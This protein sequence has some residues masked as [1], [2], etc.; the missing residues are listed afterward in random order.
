MSWMT[1]RAKAGQ[2][3]PM[4]AI[5]LPVVLGM[6]AFS[7]DL[8]KLWVFK[9]HLQ[10]AADASALASVQDLG[11]Y[12]D[13]TQPSPGLM[14]ATVEATVNT[15]AS[16]NLC[17]FNSGKF[18]L[19]KPPG[20]PGVGLSDF[21]N[22]DCGAAG[23]GAGVAPCLHDWDF[24]QTKLA[25][26]EDTNCYEWPYVKGGV[27]HWDQ[28]EVR[29]TKPAYLD[30]AGLV[31]FTNPSWQMKRSVATFS[32][33]TSTN[34]VEQPSTQV[35][36]TDPDTT[37]TTTTVID[38]T[39]S[40]IVTTIP[41]ATHTTTTPASTVTNTTTTSIF[42]G[43]TGGAAFLKSTAC[44]SDPGGAALQ[45]AG[46]PS[47]FKT[48]I[49]NG[50]F[51]INGANTHHADHLW[52]GKHGVAGCEIKGS[53]ADI[54][55]I[56]GPFTPLDWPIAPP[57]PAPPV[58]CLNTDVA[59]INNGWK[60]S[61]PPG[62]YCWTSGLLTMAANSGT[63]DGYS[64]YAPSIS[65]NSNGM[66]FNASLACGTR[67]VLFDAYAGDFT[68]SGGG[69]TLNGDIYAANGNISV[70]GGGAFSGCG[71]METNK[72]NIGGNFAGY[73]GTGPGE[74]GGV[75]TTTFTTTTVIPASTHTTTDPDTTVTTTTVSDG[76]TS[77]VVTTTPGG[78]TTYTIAGTTYTVTN[79][80]STDIGLGE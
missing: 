79:T 22:F 32:P 70:T 61:H 19:R 11:P 69:D 9:A 5:A 72:M 78:T 26:S 10:N 23:A 38:G 37:L 16:D 68:M 57:S 77:T 66:I 21:R 6:M 39:T 17:G 47:T 42:S 12:L 28:V 25:R 65:L 53:G 63:L 30:F 76:T 44:N 33:Q 49:L 14:A 29:L 50:G 43:G 73:N 80:T 45:W 20:N 27:N 41:G 67:K 3:I 7:L 48:I 74:G 52:V 59:T 13:G 58:G 60:A 18:W 4:Y 46:A 8:G 71:Y 2:I 62:V 15:Y 1:F 55:Q 56:S 51:A 54:T 36:S 34:T 75:T 40:T 24:P 64:F 31:G 35:V